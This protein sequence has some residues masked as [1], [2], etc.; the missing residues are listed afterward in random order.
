M[1]NVGHFTDRNKD[2]RAAGLNSVGFVGDG[3]KDCMS[4]IHPEEMASNIIRADCAKKQTRQCRPRTPIKHPS[5]LG[6]LFT[7][8]LQK[9]RFV[10]FKEKFYEELYFKKG[11]VGEVMPANSKPDSVTNWSQ[12]FGKTSDGEGSLYSII[13]P[14]K[15]AEEVNREYVD[16]H[17]NHIVSHNHYF[18]AE[19]ID[20][21][22]AKPYDRTNAY[23]DFQEATDSGL[24]V[25]RCLVQGE[26]RLIVI[27]KVLL[28]FKKRTVAPLGK[29]FKKYPYEVPDI[30]FGRT[31]QSDG[32]VKMLIDNVIPSESTDRL[33][34]AIGHLNSLRLT[35]SRRTDFH[36]YILLSALRRK[37][38]ESTGHL[39]FE[40]IMQVLRNS[41]IRIDSHKIRT[42]LSHFR[43]IVDECCETERVNYEDFCRLLSIHEPMPSLGNDT[44]LSNNDCS[45]D[46][47]YRLL[48]ADRNKPLKPERVYVVPSEHHDDIN[49]H[50]KD[51]VTPDVATVR[52][53]GSSDFE[54]LR[55]KSDIER[56]FRAIIPKESFEMV[57]QLLMEKHQDQDQVASVNQFRDQID[58]FRKTLSTQ[59][60]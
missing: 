56:I 30:V 58:I 39:P 8:E 32:S 40:R 13:M 28:D 10:S 37:D 15:S 35:L 60:C 25:K 41:Y 38:K 9:S 14:E 7:S 16:G 43:L 1:A 29:K 42:A 3:A 27:G 31:Y 17:R 36:M 59:P 21:H 2:I 45:K 44:V 20:R 52:G 57:W 22:Y 5:T 47:T 26:D 18:P 54:C 50:I 12:T 51:L 23:G 11:R 6:D 55:P 49:T 46:T 24:N 53:L 4:I 19:Q 33:M 48:C 34:S